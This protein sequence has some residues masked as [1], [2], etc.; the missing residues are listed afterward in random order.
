MLLVGNQTGYSS[1]LSPLHTAFLH[2][3]KLFEYKM[4]I[5]FVK[6]PLVVEQNNIANAS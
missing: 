5:K 4:G 1:I 6:E 3:I 2:T